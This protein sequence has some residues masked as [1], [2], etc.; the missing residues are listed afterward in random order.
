MFMKL[1]SSTKVKMA[2]LPISPMTVRSAPDNKI[3]YVHAVVII[4]CSA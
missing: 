1:E 2:Y 4:L 3:L